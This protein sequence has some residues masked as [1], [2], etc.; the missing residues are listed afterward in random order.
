MI[1]LNVSVFVFAVW[2][3]CYLLAREGAQRRFQFAALGLLAYAA[4]VA[5]AGI[6]GS[7]MR[8]DL[9][10]WQRPLVWLPAL[11]W[12]GTLLNL[13][14]P[15]P[16]TE[17]PADWR[18]QINRWLLPAAIILYLLGVVLA[19]QSPTLSAPFQLGV[20]LLLLA[21][22]AL[23]LVQLL[24]QLRGSE[25]RVQRPLLILL[26]ASI[27]FVLGV[28]LLFLPQT[29]I[30]SG[31]VLLAIGVDLLTLGMLIAYLDAQEAG[32][33]LRR[34][35]LHSFVLSIGVSLLF[36]SQLGFVFWLADLDSAGS[37]AALFGI[38]GSAV[39]IQTFNQPL[40]AWLEKL[41][42]AR[43]PRRLEQQSTYREALEAERRQREDQFDPK[44]IPEEE[45][46][47][48]T[49][50]AFS[51]FNNLPRLAASPLTQMPIIDQRLQAKGADQ[52]TLTRAAELR[53]LLSECVERLKPGV[54]GHFSPSDEW[55]FYNALYY[56]YV[57][58]VKPY[59]RKL[60]LEEHPE[61]V[62]AALEWFRRQVP[63]RT[64]YNWQ[65]QAA[66]LIATD[67]LEKHQTGSSWQ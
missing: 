45:L 31:W 30:Q 14:P 48:L 25:S 57:L 11:F 20:S 10:V 51:H 24:R 37:R 18:L 4:A 19:L 9:S 59:S 21:L 55:R 61:D 3:G 67:L 32:E 46:K 35:M 43:N 49:R 53:T 6:N 1:W 29:W 26:I 64:L 8:V 27:F 15:E 52:Q 28:S 23:T 41:I 50:R 40:Q 58:G 12:L 62:Q 2:L 60:L 34:H 33:G 5:L 39:T 36:G 63:E 47:R 7:E 54:N 17:E 13:T 44:G 22:L 42:W 66:A 56:P 16:E 65:N 38:L